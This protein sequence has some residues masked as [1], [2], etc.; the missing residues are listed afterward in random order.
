MN[1]DPVRCLVT[2]ANSR[3][4]LFLQAAWR[5][6]ADVVPVWCARRPPADIV[7]APGEEVPD[8]P[9]C[10]AVAALWG[11]TAG[12]AR[13]LA[14]NSTLAHAAWQLARACGA[15][16]VIHLSSAA[17]YGPG[18]RLQE[19]RHPAPAGAYGTAKLEMERTIADLP[20]DGLRHMILRV[21]NVIGADS[22]SRSLRDHTRSVTLDRFD[23]GTGPCRSYVAPGDLA[24]VLAALMGLPAGSL[25]DVLNVA[26]PQPVAMADLARAAGHRVIWR[27]APAT[28]QACVSLDTARLERLLPGIVRCITPE[29]MI[30]DWHRL[31]TRD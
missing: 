4:G 30:A 6:N 17:I 24:R 21:A 12:D 28:A 29:R 1:K 23:D 20:H 14:Q 18:T 7:W 15:E 26:A 11:P 3:I 22:L 5:A 27:A 9:R 25:P 16:R 2:G 8:L 10:D 19:I 13:T 31:E